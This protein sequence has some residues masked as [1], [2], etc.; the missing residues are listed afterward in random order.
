MMHRRSLMALLGIGPVAASV[1]PSAPIEPVESSHAMP[2]GSPQSSAST[3]LR[4]AFKAGL[5]DKE[6]LAFV[7]ERE[8]YRSIDY[9]CTVERYK[10]F[11]PLAKR[12]LI[13]QAKRERAFAQFIDGDAID[14]WSLA[15][16]FE[17]KVT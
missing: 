14:F 2:L 6:T 13:E 1:L 7:L 11:S 17:G 10:S 15:R 16:K 4:A 3:V 9:E 12:R 8:S 5:V